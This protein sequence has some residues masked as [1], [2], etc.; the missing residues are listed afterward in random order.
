MKALLGL[1]KLS[2]AAMKN[3]IELL[4]MTLLSIFANKNNILSVLFTN[5]SVLAQYTK[6]VNSC[7][8]SNTVTS[9]LV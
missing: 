9:N 5:L 7:H 4:R 1:C 6:L 8:L 3:I 2:F